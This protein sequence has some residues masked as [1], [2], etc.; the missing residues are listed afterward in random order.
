MRKKFVAV[1]LAGISALAIL[2][3]CEI[4]TGPAKFDFDR[5]RIDSVIIED[6]VKGYYE[7]DLRIELDVN[8]LSQFMSMVP[9]LE[10]RDG[11][12]GQGS[13]EGG[14]YNIVCMNEDGEA[15]YTFTVDSSH[16]LNME[17]KHLWHSEGL[18]KFFD[19]LEDKYG[20][21]TI[22]NKNRKPGPEYFSL[23][24]N[25]AKIKF[26]EYTETNFDEGVDYTLTAK[27]VEELKNGIS[28][29]TFLP[30]QWPK[31]EDYLYSFY[32][33]DKWGSIS[34]SITVISNHEVNINGRA[35]DYDSVKDWLHKIE[36][37]SGYVRE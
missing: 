35:V 1:A 30:E 25:I 3:A 36:E 22:E 27:E 21:T 29:A 9:E 10:L 14:A 4:K 24:D 2:T 33:V 17:D 12:A 18:D 13:G 34:Y 15:L 11:Q 6:S 16:N 5:T 19:E 8:E 26:S 28:Q 7:D 32:T 23:A 31:K 20:L 37:V